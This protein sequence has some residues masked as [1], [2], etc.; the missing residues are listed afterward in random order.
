MSFL[1]AAVD[2]LRRSP[3]Q[4]PMHYREITEKALAE[5]VIESAGRTPDATLRAQIGVDNRRREGRGDR[6]RFLELG[7]A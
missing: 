4:A 5:G 3:G 7:V 1:D 2:V 6:P